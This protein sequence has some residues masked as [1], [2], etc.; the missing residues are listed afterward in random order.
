[1]CGPSLAAALPGDVLW[2]L[3]ALEGADGLLGRVQPPNSLPLHQQGFCLRRNCLLS[4]IKESS[5]TAGFSSEK[6]YRLQWIFF[7][8][9]H[10]KT[11]V[12]RRLF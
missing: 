12:T 3:S 11:M 6:G 2:D 7:V 1:M 5:N 9:V 4:T 8:C 10:L